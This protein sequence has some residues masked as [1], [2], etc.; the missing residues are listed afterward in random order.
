MA[1]RAETMR[2]PAWRVRVRRVES[3]GRVFILS[4]IQGRGT[5]TEGASRFWP[6]A[7]RFRD[8]PNMNV[9]LEERPAKASRFRRIVQ[10]VG[11]RVIW[12]VSHKDAPAYGRP[13][14]PRWAQ[15]YSGRA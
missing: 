10:A 11:S 2:N 12:W 3:S 5:A 6:R 1:S 14:D 15:S 9:E 8:E 13:H 7:N 4:T